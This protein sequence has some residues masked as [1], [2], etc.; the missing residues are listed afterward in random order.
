M[1]RSDLTMEL[2]TTPL[3]RLMWLQE[4][5]NWFF[6]FGYQNHLTQSLN[7]KR[8][9]LFTKIDQPNDPE[10]GQR[11][12]SKLC[13]PP[14]WGK[15]YNKWYAD[16]ILCVDFCLTECC[17]P[18]WIYQICTNNLNRWGA[19]RLSYPLNIT[20]LHK[21]WQTALE[22]LCL[23]EEQNSCLLNCWLQFSKITSNYS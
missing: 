21:H 12:K 16:F 2:T 6:S 7:K 10:N 17:L 9:F 5:E 11:V 14:L 19:E 23:F 8:R 22:K 4:P 20:R 1:L 18:R 3:T 15:K 13:D